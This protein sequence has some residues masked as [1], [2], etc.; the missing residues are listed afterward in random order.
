MSKNQEQ[1][2]RRSRFLKPSRAES[3]GGKGQVSM[4]KVREGERGRSRV[5]SPSCKPLRGVGESQSRA[6]VQELLPRAGTTWAGMK[7]EEGALC[8]WLC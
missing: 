4:A 1:N 5:N 6:A 2:W 8:S 7:A 3:T